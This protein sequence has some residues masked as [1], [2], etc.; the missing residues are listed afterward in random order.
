MK[1]LTEWDFFCIFAEVKL[2]LCEVKVI[3][4]KSTIKKRNA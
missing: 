3:V 1:R 4:N 2:I